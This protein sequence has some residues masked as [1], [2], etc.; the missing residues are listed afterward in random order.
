MHWYGWQDALAFHTVKTLNSSDFNKTRTMVTKT[1][2]WWSIYNKVKLFY[3]ENHH[4]SIPPKDDPTKCLRSWISYQRHHAQTLT[5]DQVKALESI[6]YKTV[7]MHCQRYEEQWHENFQQLLKEENPNKNEKLRFWLMRQR[8]MKNKGELS[9]EKIKLLSDHGHN[10]EP[11]YTPR[12]G[13]TKPKKWTEENWV[14]NYQKLKK[15]YD[16][17]G[18]C[19]VPSTYHED[20]SLAS[21]VK[22]QRKKYRETGVDGKPLLDGT[23][24][25]KLNEIGFRWNKETVNKKPMKWTEKTW[26]QSYQKLKEYYDV[27]GNCHVP[28]TYREDQSLA[29]WVKTQRN[30][31]RKTG[32]DGKSMLDETKIEKLNGIGFRW[33]SRRSSPQQEPV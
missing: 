4:L 24:I 23:R 29:G 27:H 28:S 21:W 12:C 32:V 1:E 15:Y 16:V 19:H 3:D 5:E 6:N 22:T 17:H 9:E 30:K 33:N 26:D 20:P 31:Y 8:E 10:L 2:Q 13:E 7:K 18:N 11:I 14:R 25:E